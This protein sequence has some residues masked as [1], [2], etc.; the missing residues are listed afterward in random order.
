MMN[1]EETVIPYQHAGLISTRKYIA[2]RPE[3][4][5][6]VVKAIVEGAAVVRKDPETTKRA[7]SVRM[8]LRDPKDLEETYQQLHRFT[9]PRPYPSLEGFK[10][11][12]NDLSKRVPAAKTADPRDFA[13]LRFVEEFDKSG[14]I[15]SL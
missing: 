10:A 9:Q 12:L 14:Y 3:I 6:R 13:D 7:L 8:R 11:I 1:L 5:R 15:D 2:A 4:T